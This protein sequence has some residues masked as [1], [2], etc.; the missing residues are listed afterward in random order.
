MEYTPYMGLIFFCILI[1]VAV[2]TGAVLGF[3]EGAKHPE[4]YNKPLCTSGKSMFDMFLD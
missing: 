4:K 3:I 2:I 1:V